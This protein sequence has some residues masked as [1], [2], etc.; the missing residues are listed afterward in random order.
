[1][2]PRS[3]WPRSK[4]ALAAL[5]LV[6]TACPS[7]RAEPHPTPPPTASKPSRG[8]TVTV[9]YP[10]EP[11]TLDPFAAAGDE[12][13]ARDIVRAV[14]PALWRFGPQGA[15]ERWLLASDP[16][17]A[18]RTMTVELRPDAV[19][20]DGKA[21]TVA[22]LTATWRRARALFPDYARIASIEALTSKRARIRFTAMPA[23]PDD[24][25]SAG[26]GV[27]PAHVRA[28]ANWSVGGGAFV[29][30]AWHRG[31]DV[32]LVRNPRAWGTVPP[33][34]SIRFVFVPDPDGARALL[35]QGK[36]DVLGP[37]VTPEW[38]RLLGSTPVSTDEGPT[39]IGLVLNDTRGAL[40]DPVVRRALVQSIDRARIV[41]GEIQE[42]G[43]PTTSTD[44]STTSAPS[45]PDV[46][47]ARRSLDADGWSGSKPRKK[48][49]VELSFT[50]ATI[51]TEPL[52]QLLARAVQFQ[53][54]R[55]GF[56][57]QPLALDNDNLWRKWIP[58]AR[59]DA[60][61]VVWRSP[62]G[63]APRVHS[64]LVVPFATLRVS[65][66]VRSDVICGA[67]ANASADG[68]F[69]NAESWSRAPCA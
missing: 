27:I 23:H 26:L 47:G 54:A 67:R 30:G 25:F 39:W 60:A 11:A 64:A 12:P 52:A 48:H 22:D 37:Y 44:P 29:V 66:A 33:L 53:A 50:L 38:L 51:S 10:S 49:G 35:A 36:I 40:R 42:Q 18:G 63:G 20:S 6:A 45:P 1:M 28:Y 43:H 8:G 56:D 32:V 58:G 19:W 68:P 62:P 69:W 31:L 4:R 57:V 46:A 13:A 3:G 41:A 15:R 59:F 9:A 61:L 55:A 2:A 16:V 14:M 65:L 34:D 21:I 5:L 7:H 24:L 17:I